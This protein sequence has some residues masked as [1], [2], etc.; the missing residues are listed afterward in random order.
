MSDVARST[1]R[2]DGLCDVCGTHVA[3]LQRESIAMVQSLDRSQGG[4]VSSST[5]QR[6]ASGAGETLAD[7]DN[8][9]LPLTTSTLTENHKHLRNTSS[10][11]NTL[12]NNQSGLPMTTTNR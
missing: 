7:P 3:L 10:S 1:L 12:R 9:N 5:L 11:D 2:P 4:H 6:Y 8:G